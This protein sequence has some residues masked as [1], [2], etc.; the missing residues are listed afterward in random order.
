MQMAAAGISSASQLSRKLGLPRQTI[1]KWLN[2]EIKEISPANLY[3]LADLLDCSAR[4]LAVN[5][6]TPYRAVRM[7]VDEKHLFDL[8]RALPESVRESWVNS[9]QALLNATDSRSTASP[10]KI[11]QR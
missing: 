6:G 5:T 7:T 3:R 8:Y 10:F 1:A 11:K 2:D 9:G 4:W